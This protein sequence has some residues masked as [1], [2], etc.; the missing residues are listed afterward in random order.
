MKRR[1][2]LNLVGLSSGYGLFAPLFSRLEAQAQTGATLQRF[3]QYEF[4]H[5][6]PLSP[7]Q[8]VSI[9]NPDNFEFKDNYAPFNQFK[10][11]IQLVHSMKHLIGEEHLHGAP[12][13]Y[14]AANAGSPA[15]D[16]KN[17]GFAGLDQVIAREVGKFTLK[18]SLVMHTPG[19]VVEGEDNLNTAFGPGQNIEG[20]KNAVEGFQYLFGSAAG[21]TPAE[22]SN[23]LARRKSL[24]DVMLTDI[25]K[26]RTKVA[27]SQIEQVDKYLEELRALE[28]RL[29][30]SSPKTAPMTSC[31]NPMAPALDPRLLPRE[32]RKL[33][34]F[35]KQEVQL[36]AMEDCYA[37]INAAITC[38]ATNVIY[39][40]HRDTPLYFC[41]DFKGHQAWHG[42]PA[43]LSDGTT[44]S[45]NVIQ[46]RVL[47]MSVR[48]S[49]RFRDYLASVQEG[50]GTA[51]DN[52]C[53]MLSS[54]FGG[55]HHGGCNKVSYL[56]FGSAG[57]KL[58]TGKAID[59]SGRFG[60]E[61][62]LT[63]SRSFGSKITQFGDGLDPGSNVIA[64][65]L[66]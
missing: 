14:T 63:L 40:E 13:N 56:T 44:L 36:Q 39:F 46:S 6:L 37:L 18:P 38:G 15:N 29:A 62:F 28:L 17:P 59:G 30:G 53:L 22:T 52:T 58:N 8:L 60:A 64:D 5:G 61:Y 50:A 9:T 24:L 66:T 12:R 16:F 31:Q 42:K 51:L 33:R 65:M 32:F 26:L 20:I 48:D 54:A 23:R 2:F 35:D 7:G 19:T 3:I 25:K 11:E 55:G 41:G 45:A 21:M 27:G 47:D 10:N 57:G 49:L 43:N 1:S 34:D 4:P